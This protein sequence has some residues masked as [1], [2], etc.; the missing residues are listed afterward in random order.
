M[1]LISKMSFLLAVGL[2]A[3][4]LMPEKAESSQAAWA[5]VTGSGVNYFQAGLTPLF[6]LLLSPIAPAANTTG[7]P[8]SAISS[9]APTCSAETPGPMECSAGGSF[10]EIVCSTVCDGNSF[11]SAE[12]V[13]ASGTPAQCSTFGGPR[14]GCS[15]LLGS[16]S[17]PDDALCSAVSFGGDAA[18]R[19]STAG[20]A[21]LA[22][23]SVRQTMAR[24]EYIN[25][26]SAWNFGTGGSQNVRCSVMGEDMV[27]GACSSITYGSG[28]KNCSA[29]TALSQCSVKVDD[30]G[31]YN[32]K[33]TALRWAPAQT[34]SA[35]PGTPGHCSVIGGPAGDLCGSH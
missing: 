34:C 5:P 13:S 22:V 29:Y 6:G 9:P 20:P 1:R 32:G 21:D 7:L 31:E 8:S 30:R 26:C 24:T 18:A 10:P 2:L 3:L 15:I 14:A 17:N 4:F 12:N 27:K 33:C 35:A 19:C 11:C 25:E 28:A 16:V 23:C